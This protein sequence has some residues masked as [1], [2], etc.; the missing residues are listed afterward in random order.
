MSTSFSHSPHL[1]SPVPCISCFHSSP[2][3]P[4]FVPCF[5]FIAHFSAPFDPL[6]SLSLAPA[7]HFTALLPQ[8][9]PFCSISPLAL[10]TVSIHLPL[11]PPHLHPCIICQF[12]PHSV[13]SLLFPNFPLYFIGL[14]KVPQP[15]MLPVHLPPQTLPGPLSPSRIML[16]ARVQ[17]DIATGKL[18]ISS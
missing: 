18:R 9:A 11:T 5:P 6:L 12:L 1:L 16:I 14:M 4:Y 10:V 17:N 13:P 8:L 3:C 7:L 2:T 15:E